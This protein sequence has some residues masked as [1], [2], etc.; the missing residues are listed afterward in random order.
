VFTPADDRVL[1]KVE[2]DRRFAIAIDGEIWSPWF[3]AL[4]EPVVSP[5]GTRAL[6]RAVDSGTYVRQV[7]PIGDGFPAGARE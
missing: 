3:D 7:V 5:D 4:W 1:A 6:I 2:R